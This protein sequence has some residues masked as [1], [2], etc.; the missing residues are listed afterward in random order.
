[1]DGILKTA[2][3]VEFEKSIIESSEDEE[4]ITLENENSENSEGE[5][6]DEE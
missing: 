2:A 4:E 6:S 3:M 1:M 5:S